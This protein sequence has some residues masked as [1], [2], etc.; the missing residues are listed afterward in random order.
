VLASIIGAGGCITPRLHVQ[1]VPLHSHVPPMKGQIMPSSVH[2]ARRAGT[3]VGQS[4]IAQ[5]AHF[6]LSQSHMRAP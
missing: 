5:H 4:D 6:E 2:A 3:A 1:V